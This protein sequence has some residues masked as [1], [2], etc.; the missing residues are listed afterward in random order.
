MPTIKNNVVAVFSCT[1]N[2]KD[3][4]NEAGK[5]WDEGRQAEAV[6]KLAE[7]IPGLP[8]VHGVPLLTGHYKAVFPYD[9]CVRIEVQF[10]ED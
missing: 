2:V 10:H 6:Y 7:A 4:L 3:I 5:I 9:N 8:I 1:D